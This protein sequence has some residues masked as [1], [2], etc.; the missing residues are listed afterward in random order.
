M[1]NPANTRR[2]GFTLIELLVVI[3]IIA[4]LIALLL[5]AVQAARAAARRIQCTNNLKQLALATMNYES[6]QGIFPPGQ[7]KMATK[8]PWG[9]TLFVGLLPFVEQGSLYNSWNFNY[10]FDNLYGST[11]RVVHQDRRIPLSGRHHPEQPRAERQHL[12]R[13]VRHHQLRR[14]R[15]LANAP[16][17]GGHQ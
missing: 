6:N 11:S 7:M 5:P 13:V 10:G 14:Q 9:I 16:V 3:A 2:S 17:L 1:K 8:P 12:E 15:R 4:V